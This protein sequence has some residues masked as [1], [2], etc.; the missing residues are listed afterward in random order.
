MGLDSARVPEFLR[1]RLDGGPPPPLSC[2]P[3]ASED[4]KFMTGEQVPKDLSIIYSPVT[5][6]FGCGFSA[7]TLSTFLHLK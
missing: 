5:I 3:C 1:S 4:P 7:R 2:A 6:H